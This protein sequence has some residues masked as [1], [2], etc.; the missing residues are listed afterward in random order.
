MRI[1]PT[2]IPEVLLL[3]PHRHKDSRGFF[4]ELYNR[5]VFRDFGIWNEFIQDNM[6]YSERLGTVRG[7]HY[8]APPFAQA[9]LVRCTRGEILD[10]CVDI[11]TGSPT[12]GHIVRR[13]L[14]ARN[15]NQ[16]YVPVGFAHGFS[17]LTPQVEVQYKV[18]NN[19]APESEKGIRF[20]DPSLAIDWALGG[21]NAVVSDKDRDLPSLSAVTA[22]FA[23]DVADEV[24][25]RVS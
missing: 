2:E 14:S 12:F 17:T 3:A 18:D 10:V 23:Y 7:L 4:S 16:I 11:R 9:K 1:E 8:Q 24:A 25:R 15:M 20:D 22:D 21:H 5:D 13:V 19:Y 6:S